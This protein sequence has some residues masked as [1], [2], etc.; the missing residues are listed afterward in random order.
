M[1]NIHF[2]VNLI[3]KAD[4][5]YTIGNSDYKWQVYVNSING[6]S[7]SDALLPTVSST[8]NGKVLGVSSGSWAV[9]DAPSGL[10]SVSSTDNGKVLQV[11]S[12]AW[13]A[14]TLTIPTK[15]SD[16][17]NDSGFVT[18]DTTYSTFVQSGSSAASGLV[19]AP[20]STAGTTAFLCEDGTWKIPTDTTYSTFVG[21]GSSAAAGLVPAPSSTAGTSKFLCED[22]TWAVPTDTTYSVMT[23]ATS[24]TAGASGLVP[25]PTTGDVDKF[26]AGDGTYKSGGLPMVILSYGN[27]N[28]ADFEAAYKNNV[29]VYCRAS[30]NSNPATGTQGRMA[31]MAYTN[32]G[33][34]PTE[35]EFQY[36]RSVSTHKNTQMGDEVYV[37]KLNKTSGWSVTKRLAS[38]QSIT[39]TGITVGYTA[40]TNVV[41]LT[42]DVTV[43]DSLTDTST[44]AALSA[45][46]GKALQDTIGST[47]MGT[48]A[49][50]LTGAIAEH[51]GDI[52][53]LN[54]QIASKANAPVRLT[55]VGKITTSTS[56]A[57]TGK[58]VT[59]PAGSMYI[60]RGYG[61]YTSSRCTGLVIASDNDP[62]H[63]YNYYAAYLSNTQSI[64]C[65]GYTVNSITFYLHAQYAS[66]AYNDVGIEGIYIT[67]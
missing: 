65:C 44:T 50:T 41:T 17:Q 8:D 40:N 39:G 52:T 18:T 16:L 22:G 30:S 23:G 13:S 56:L 19:P 31:F 43:S 12:G 37:Y 27:S 46:K 29:I 36:Y 47:T 15:V 62:S 51:E 61:I 55:D 9:V 64:S 60:V 42:N 7:V 6:K 25:A 48:T 33:T 5:T 24:S 58:S 10:P 63:T 67:M 59:I 28:W 20:S 49:T 1:A 53:T 57:Y 21:S 66:A 26:L 2:G 14:S 4:N 54:N 11:S 45:A 32:D 34:N 35:V 38:I 3:P